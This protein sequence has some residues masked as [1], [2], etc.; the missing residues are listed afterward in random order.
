MFIAWKYRSEGGLIALN[1]DGD[2][3]ALEKLFAYIFSNAKCVTSSTLR[4]SEAVSLH[5][6]ASLGASAK[7]TTRNS[8]AH[9]AERETQGLNMGSCVTAKPAGL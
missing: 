1:V 6:P 7:L 9:G 8:P 4:Q 5:Y 2:E 3:N